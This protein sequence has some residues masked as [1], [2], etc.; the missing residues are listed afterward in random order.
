MSDQLNDLIDE[1]SVRLE[2]PEQ[3]LLRDLRDLIYFTITPDDM[4]RLIDTGRES[5]CIYRL[6]AFTE[7]PPDK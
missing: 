7:Y 3:L 1:L 5:V 4:G 6:S 2:R